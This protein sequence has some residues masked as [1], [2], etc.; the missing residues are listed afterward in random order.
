MSETSTRTLEDVLK[1]S[2]AA[3]ARAR[4]SQARER[5]SADPSGSAQ[6]HR[7]RHDRAPD[8]QPQ[9]DFRLGKRYRNLGFHRRARSSSLGQCRRAHGSGRQRGHRGVQPARRSI[10][11]VGLK[12]ERGRQEHFCLQDRRCPS[13]QLGSPQSS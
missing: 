5:K 10:R 2:Q 4:E 1:D 3:A 12:P 13:L 9:A 11:R 8:R 7:E 6:D